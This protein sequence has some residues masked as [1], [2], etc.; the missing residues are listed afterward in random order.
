MIAAVRSALFAVIFYL[1]SVPIVVAAVGV[2]VISPAAVVPIARV[3]ASWFALTTRVILGI[4]FRIEGRI[5]QHAVVVAFKHQSAYETILVLWL[6][7]RPAVVLKSELLGIPLWGAAARAHGVIPVDRAG[8]A[9][10]LRAMLKAGNAAK[11]AG[12]PVVIFPEGTRTAPGDAPEL[13]A[14]LAGLYRALKLPLVPVALDSG[15]C[16]PK[17]FIK[18]SGTV[19]FA[20]K[21][22]IPPGLD[23]ADIEARVHAAINALNPA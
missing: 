22:P 23:R 9:S 5:P 12:R 16:W 20:F 1:G 4:R 13:R 3:W 6:F 14:G 8:S 10:A 19:T 17:G 11:A 7:T 18:H 21:D 15:K 2:S